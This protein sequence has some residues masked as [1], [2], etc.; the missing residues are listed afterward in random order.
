M[1]LTF[2]IHA[3]DEARDE[4]VWN[5]AILDRGFDSQLLECQSFFGAG[6]THV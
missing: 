1:R 2:T 4:N 6:D 3:A 5:L